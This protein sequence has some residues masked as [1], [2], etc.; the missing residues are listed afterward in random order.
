MEYIKRN[1]KIEN[2][3]ETLRCHFECVDGTSRAKGCYNFEK[4]KKIKNIVRHFQRSFQMNFTK[5]EE[6]YIVLVIKMQYDK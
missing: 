4:I 5:M 6:V 1:L 2:K 3:M